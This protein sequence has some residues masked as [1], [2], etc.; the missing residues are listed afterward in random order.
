MEGK[1]RKAFDHSR[2]GT[3]GRKERGG[4][5]KKQ[6]SCTAD[7]LKH[8]R[9]RKGGAF[10]EKRREVADRSREKNEKNLGKKKRALNLSHG[11]EKRNLF[12]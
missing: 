2:P 11:G 6:L 12:K 10:L 1:K 4:P 7:S 9:R 5:E 3:R 8:K